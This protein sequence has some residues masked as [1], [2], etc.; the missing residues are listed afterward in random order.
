VATVMDDMRD[1]D[2]HRT[3]E[4]TDLY[5]FLRWSGG[6]M[7]NAYSTPNMESIDK[8]IFAKHPFLKYWE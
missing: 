2:G 5:R 4:E 7:L 6:G 3:I 8:R 1:K